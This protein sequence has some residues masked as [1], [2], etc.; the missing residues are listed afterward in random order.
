MKAFAIGTPE[1]TKPVLASAKDQPFEIVIFQPCAVGEAHRDLAAV[2]LRWVHPDYGRTIIDGLTFTPYKTRDIRARISCFL[3]H[4]SLWMMCEMADE[5]FLVLESDALFTRRF[6]PAELDFCNY[7][8]VSINDPRGATRRASE[9]HGYLHSCAI[10]CKADVV[11]V[12]FVDSNL[13]IPQGLPGHSAYVIDP[14]F[15]AK[16]TAKAYAVGAMPNDAL[17]NRQWFVGELGCLTRYA[18]K[19]S[20][21]PSAIA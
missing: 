1:E 14:A 4:F 21:R 7:G 15:A 2:G 9:F 3:A 10:E 16:L 11:H 12:P 20:G 17:A 13:A 5:P 6:D 8:M 19:T 18:T